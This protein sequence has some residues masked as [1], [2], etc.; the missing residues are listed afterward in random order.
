MFLVFSGLQLSYQ[1][2]SNETQPVNQRLSH[3]CQSLLREGQAVWFNPAV[4]VC[5]CVFQ[6]RHYSRAS[7]IN[8]TSSMSRALLGNSLHH[9]ISH[10][11]SQ[12][13]GSFN[14]SIKMETALQSRQRRAV[15]HCTAHS[16]SNK[17]EIE[18]IAVQ[19]C[20][21]GVFVFLCGDL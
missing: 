21:F 10:S 2:W 20:W 19:Q 4:S 5:V 16:Y 8:K 3:G 1:K 7:C 12:H 17:C 11:A 6:K 15:C 18:L 9:S 13:N 14:L